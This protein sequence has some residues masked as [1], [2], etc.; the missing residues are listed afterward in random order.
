M[1]CAGREAQEISYLWR[2]SQEALMAGD[3]AGAKSAYAEA[4][5][6]SAELLARFR[7][8]K[9]AGGELDAA[10]KYIY[11]QWNKNRT[12]TGNEPVRV[13]FL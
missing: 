11:V 12:L 13:L 1:G 8:S 2:D 4:E 7:K 6:C 3:D 10:K 5:K 9:E